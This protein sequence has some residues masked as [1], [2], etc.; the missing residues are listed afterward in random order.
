MRFLGFCAEWFSAGIARQ[1][2]IDE[3]FVSGD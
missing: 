3:R 2:S 1:V